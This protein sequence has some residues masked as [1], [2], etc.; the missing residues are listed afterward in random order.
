MA[1]TKFTTLYIFLLFKGSLVLGAHHLLLKPKRD[2]RF[3]PFEGPNTRF[4][5]L[6][7]ERAENSIEDQES[8]YSSN[9]MHIRHIEAAYQ[10]SR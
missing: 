5:I 4:S 9:L 2:A 10:R 8:S 6:N 1:F 3:D 7:E